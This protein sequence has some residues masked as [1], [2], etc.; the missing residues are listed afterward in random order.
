MTT[1]KSKAPKT[2]APKKTAPAKAKANAKPAAATGSKTE[3]KRS[4]AL[5]KARKELRAF[6]LNY[7]E[8]SLKSPWPEHLDLAVREKTFAF[9]SVEGQPFTITCKLPESNMSALMLP[10]AKPTGYGLAKSGWVTAKFE[11]GDELPIEMLKEWIDESYRSVAPKT[12]VKKLSA[13]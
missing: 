13:L 5:D 8:T 10:F 12:L 6:G 4:S 9:I 1:R 2:T 3:S 11:E 7:P